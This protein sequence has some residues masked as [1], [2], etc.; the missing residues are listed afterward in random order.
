MG[1]RCC[2]TTLHGAL[3]WSLAGWLA[4]GQPECGRWGLGTDGLPLLL[5]LSP[6]CILTQ[7]FTPTLPCYEGVRPTWAQGSDTGASGEEGSG[8]PS[9]LSQEVLQTTMECTTS[10]WVAVGPWVRDVVAL[11]GTWVSQWLLP[12][13]W[14]CVNHMTQS[15]LSGR[16]SSWWPGS[17]PSLGRWEGVVLTAPGLAAGG[18]CWLLDS[19]PALWIGA[20]TLTSGVA[21]RP[22]PHARTRLCE[23]QNRAEN[24]PLGR[25]SWD[26]MAGQRGHHTGSGLEADRPSAQDGE[27]R[28]CKW[29]GRP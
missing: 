18:M 17:G 11:W 21:I 27:I 22:A 2:Q 10:P 9:H 1:C 16:G 15:G 5:R 19:E 25:G 20:E 8:S 7:P 28:Q 26:S 4:A 14:P 23:P 3:P 13:P 6:S 24:K 12:V 29:G